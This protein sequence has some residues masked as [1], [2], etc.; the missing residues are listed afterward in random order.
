MLCVA[1]A[2]AGCWKKELSPE[3]KQLVSSLNAELIRTKGEIL[4]ATATSASYSGG[5]IKNLIDARIEILRT[6]QALLEQ[7]VQ[8]IEGGA[9]VKV[10][11]TV[12]DI[13]QGAANTLS[14]EIET[15]KA[16][17][18]VAQQEA[19]QYT[20]G[21]IRVLKLTNVA[22]Q[23]Q[24]LSMLEQRLFT[25]KYGL[26]PK[27]GGLSATGSSPAPAA[28]AEPTPMSQSGPAIAPADGPFGFAKGLTRAEIENMLGSQLY[29]IDE[30]KYLYGTK[31]APKPNP[32]FE[33]VALVISPNAGLCEIRAVGQSISTN[34]FGNQLQA[35]FKSLRE[36]LVA[37]YGVPSDTDA[38]MPGSLWKNPEDWMMGLYKKDRSLISV[39][40]KTTATP[41]RSSLTAIY[42]GVSASNAETGYNMLQYQFDNAG[43]CEAELKRAAQGSL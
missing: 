17:I 38:L 2:L 36:S 41:L 29:V 22:T 27:I 42:L 24:T 5:L 15:T 23:Q 11:V 19:D 43:L 25:V 40:R 39:W 30:S 9:P 28:S 13:D 6:N 26:N 10:E 12:S 35:A 34:R 31:T 18:A 8:A 14:A 16:K 33:Q 37:V 32:L 4:T 3:D 1:I 21:L 20:G 7:R